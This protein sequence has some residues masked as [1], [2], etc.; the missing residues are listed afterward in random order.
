[1]DRSTEAAA[2]D[3]GDCTATKGKAHRKDQAEL[4]DTEKPPFRVAQFHITLNALFGRRWFVKAHDRDAQRHQNN[5][6]NDHQK[7]M[8]TPG[9]VECAPQTR[10]VNFRGDVGQILGHLDVSAEILWSKLALQ[11][12]AA[13]TI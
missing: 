6:D 5:P 13:A 7:G 9:N 1:M 12:D 10:D 8:V 2:N 3:Q 11:L 4:V